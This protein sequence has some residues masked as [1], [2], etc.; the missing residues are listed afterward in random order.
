MMFGM[1]FLGNFEKKLWFIFL[2]RAEA[3]EYKKKI[4][5]GGILKFESI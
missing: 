3:E 5:W 2:L 1:H 4:F